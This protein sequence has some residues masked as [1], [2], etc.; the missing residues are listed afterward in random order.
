MFTLRAYDAGECVNFG[1]NKAPGYS[2]NDV[3]NYFVFYSDNNTSQ[4]FFSFEA[5]DGAINNSMVAS[6]D[7][8]ASSGM[9]IWVPNGGGSGGY[10]EY[11]FDVTAAGQ[12]RRMGQSAGP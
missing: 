7:N 4:T 3:N 2:G 6:A 1:A 5:E 9:Y 12:L 10:V 8:N 11:S